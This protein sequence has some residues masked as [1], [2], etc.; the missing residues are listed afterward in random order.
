MHNNKSETVRIMPENRGHRRARHRRGFTIVELLVV[1]GI[2][3]LLLTVLLPVLALARRSARSAVCMNHQRE[4]V[5]AML[6]RAEDHEGYLPLAGTITVRDVTPPNTGLAPLLQDTARRRYDYL[7]SN[8]SLEPVTGEDV[9]PTQLS[10]LKWLSDPDV[11]ER[12]SEL[13]PW[14]ER[15][16]RERVESLFTCPAEPPLEGS[17]RP[18]VALTVGNATGITLWPLVTH[19][20]FNEGVLGFD[21]RDPGVRRLRGRKVSIRD[22]SRTLLTGDMNSANN[23]ITVMTWRPPLDLNAGVTTLADFLPVEGATVDPV[24]DQFDR[25]RHAGRINLA[26]ADGHVDGRRIE[27]GDLQSVRVVGNDD[28]LPRGV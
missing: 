19:Y 21:D 26:F 17:E 2:I 18:S 3:S 22:P 4:I 13:W 8:S 11:P 1:I 16:G 12:V 15:G 14:L 27:A 25:N 20:G 6:G 7:E 10:V 23:F 9:A 24:K 28:T 5:R